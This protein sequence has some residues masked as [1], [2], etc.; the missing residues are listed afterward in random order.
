M[1]PSTV[2]NATLGRPNPRHQYGKSVNIGWMD[3]HAAIAK[4][5]AP[6]YP[7]LPGVWLGNSITDP[8]D[9]NYKDHWDDIAGYATL[10]AQRLA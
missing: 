8:S 3:G 9:P 5:E 1:P 4:I 2:Q 7:G 10:V 6:L